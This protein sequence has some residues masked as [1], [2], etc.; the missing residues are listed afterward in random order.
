MNIDDGKKKPDVHN[1]Y[2]KNSGLLDLSFPSYKEAS[3]SRTG[4]PVEMPGRDASS[5]QWY[6]RF[7]HLKMVRKSMSKSENLPKSQT[8]QWRITSVDR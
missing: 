2:K 1:F 5:C 4:Q 3:T 7:F 6:L 8:W